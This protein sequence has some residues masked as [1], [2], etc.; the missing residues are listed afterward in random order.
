MEESIS[1][2]SFFQSWELFAQPFLAGTISGAVLGFLGVYILIRNMVFLSAA[3]SQL[4]GLGITLSLFFQNFILTTIPPLLG[5]VS[6]TGTA[7]L[8]IT[9]KIHSQKHKNIFL[10]VLF[11]FGSSGTLI[12]GSK[13][14]QELHDIQSLLFGTA[15]AVLPSD[16]YSIVVV[17]IFMSILHIWWFRGFREIVFDRV[18][19]KIRNIPVDIL[20]FMLLASIVISLSLSTKI[21]G[22]LPTFAFSI[23][24]AIAALQI[25]SS[26]SAALLLSTLGGSLCG[27]LGYLF[28]YVYQLPVGAS[29][30]AVG[31][32]EILIVLFIKRLFTQVSHTPFVD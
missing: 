3:L 6:L 7:V 32:S 13:I 22:A 12:I 20:E 11:L 18:E 4:A 21:L 2:E 28:A 23:L 24:P 16:F 5:A 26:L 14:I 9:K 1:F 17:A 10:G 29:Q 27:S 15:V 31:I 25:A 30:A 8:I 19:A